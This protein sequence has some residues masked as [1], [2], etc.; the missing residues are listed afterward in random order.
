MCTNNIYICEDIYTEN[1]PQFK[2][3]EFGNKEEYKYHLK[4]GCLYGAL[5]DQ[6]KPVFH[7]FPLSENINN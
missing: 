2:E 1:S 4:I 3:I 7:F 5:S 6:P